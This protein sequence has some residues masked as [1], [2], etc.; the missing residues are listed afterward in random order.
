[1]Q[2][3]RAFVRRLLGGA[4]GAILWEGPSLLDGRPLVVIATSLVSKGTMANQKTGDVIQTWIL[5]RDLEPAAALGREDRSICG[6]CKLRGAQGRRRDC[7]VHIGMVGR[8]HQAYR[9]G[10]YPRLP[11]S[12]ALRAALFGGR[13]VRLGSY[14]DPAFV[15]PAVWDPVFRWSAGWIG[16]THAWQSC[17]QDLRRFLMASVDTPEER[18]VARQRGWRTF[19]VLH[20][21]EQLGER[22]IWCPA[23]QE[24][25]HKSACER[26]RLC[27]GVA[28]SPGRRDIGLYFHGPAA[29][30]EA[31][32]RGLKVING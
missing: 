1:M 14:G 24:G 6:D 20:A 18:L 29:L 5:L 7:Y 19:R 31:R 26:C 10:I 9:E 13:V 23:T 17:D 15:P 8:T 12:P 30:G 21:W 2:S 25:G 11:D 16:Y 28:D 4:R 3:R 27:D 22:E 32:F